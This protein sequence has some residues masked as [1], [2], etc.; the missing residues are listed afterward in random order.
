MTPIAGESDPPIK[1]AIATR[2]L[3]DI[4]AVLNRILDIRITFFDLQGYE[5]EYFEMKPW[6]AFCTS[7]RRARAADQ[8]CRNC[9]KLN[10]TIAKQQGDVHVYHCHNGLIEGIVPLYDRRNVYLGAMVFG[11]LRDPAVP[12]PADLSQTHRQL[13]QRLPAF[14][15]DQARDIGRLLRF[16]GEYVIEN[17]LIRRRNKPWADKLVTYITEHLAE[18]ITLD[19][20]AAV[21]GHSASFVSHHFATEFGQSPKEYISKQRMQAARSSLESGASVQ[22]TAEQLGFYDPFHFSKAFKSHR[23][24]S[25]RHFKSG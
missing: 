19:D 20:L 7:Y 5:L 4:L 24:K 8:A 21:I 10:L 11:Q 22:K 6:S 15:I 2:E 25:P 12:S 9:D 1:Y 3:N 16:I 18:R 17:E 14:G 23:G 13:F